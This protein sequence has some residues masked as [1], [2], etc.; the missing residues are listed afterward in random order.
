MEWPFL[1]NRRSMQE[2]KRSCEYLF[3]ESHHF[4]HNTANSPNINFA[5]IHRHRQRVSGVHLWRNVKGCSCLQVAK[6]VKPVETLKMLRGITKIECFVGLKAYLLLSNSKVAQEV[7]SSFNEDVACFDVSMDD[8][9]F[10]RM[11]VV[12]SGG[13]LLKEMDDLFGVG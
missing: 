8:G 5:V 3:L 9:D 7:V 4:I 10:K 1:N 6:S 12:Q 2:Q 11:E 13:Y